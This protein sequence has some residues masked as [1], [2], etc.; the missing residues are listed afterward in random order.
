MPFSAMLF[1]RTRAKNGIR[2]LTQGQHLDIP[3]GWG[4]DNYPG[5][6]FEA[7]NNPTL[8]NLQNKNL[9]RIPDNIGEITSLKSLNLDNNSIEEIP[10][11][12]GSLNNLTFL[13]L[14]RNSIQTLPTEL[15]NLDFLAFLLLRNNQFT[16]SGGGS[17]KCLCSANIKRWL[18]YYSYRPRCRL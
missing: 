18:A 11:S 1:Q 16:G 7:N 15:G 4:V 8:I 2:I 14:E 13:S 12:I 6:S 3:L 5:V 9:A 10:K 17:T